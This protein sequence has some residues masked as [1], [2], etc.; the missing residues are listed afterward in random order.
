[1]GILGLLNL[2]YFAKTY[3]TQSKWVLKSFPYPFSITGINITGLL[4]LLLLTKLSIFKT[5]SYLVSFVSSRK[6][7]GHF[8]EYG[9]SLETFNELYCM[10]T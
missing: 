5:N 3:P 8:F 2:L 7:C 4:G 1:M 10:F 6:I 9:S